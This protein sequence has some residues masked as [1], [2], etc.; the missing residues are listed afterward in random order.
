MSTPFLEKGIHRFSQIVRNGYAHWESSN[1]DGVLQ[2]IDARIKVL[3]LSSWIVLVSLKHAVAPQAGIAAFVLLLYGLS[4]LEIVPIYRRIL[5]IGVVFGVLIPFFSLFNLFSGGEP[6]LPLIRLPQP[7]ALW[8]Y[9]LPEV[10]G[11][12]REGVHGITILFLRVTNSVALSFLLLHTTPFP[13]IVRSLRLFR[14]PDVFVVVITL[15][16]KYLFLFSRTVE[17]MHLAK[18]SRLLG[19]LPDREAR[20]WVAE[21]LVVLYRKSQVRCEGIFRAMVA[22]G[23]SSDVRMR[24]FHPLKASD[25]CAATVLFGAG[26]LILAW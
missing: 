20:S 26:A 22:R 3:F 9:R 17:E 19:A 18:R 7:P 23:F 25:W 2:R 14:V 5:V 8:G 11:V 6:I 10:I 4:R 15:S 1:R 16:Y 12:T 13:D 24:A 21:R